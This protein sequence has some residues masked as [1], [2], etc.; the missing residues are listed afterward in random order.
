L[1]PINAAIKQPKRFAI[2]MLYLIEDSA[3]GNPVSPGY[4]YAFM[5]KKMVTAIPP[6]G[7]TYKY[8]EVS[9]DWRER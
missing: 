2:I 6:I 8:L 4:T 7:M 1:D 9:V 5:A 3:G